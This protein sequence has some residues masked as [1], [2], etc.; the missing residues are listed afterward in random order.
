MRE[1]LFR[2]R[3]GL[4]GPREGRVGGGRGGKGGR[5]EGRRRK[6]EKK[7]RRE[8]EV[9]PVKRK[10][11]SRYNSFF[12]ELHRSIHTTWHKGNLSTNGVDM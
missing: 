9:V 12:I 8:E 7:R 3:E 1:S 6:N 2:G 5:E 4:H 10:A 11:A